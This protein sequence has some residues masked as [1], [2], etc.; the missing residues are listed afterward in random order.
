MP[1]NGVLKKK[2]SWFYYLKVDDRYISEIYPKIAK[3]LPNGFVMAPYQRRD[4]GVGAHISVVYEK[5]KVPA[6][7]SANLEKKFLFCF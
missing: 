5:E 4:S 2:E 1:L 6:N 3:L 7:F